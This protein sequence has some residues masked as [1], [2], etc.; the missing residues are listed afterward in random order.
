MALELNIN[1]IFR[2][3]ICNRIGN[4]LS[5]PIL[6]DIQ[7]KGIVEIDETINECK[8]GTHQCSENAACEYLKVRRLNQ[9][10]FLLVYLKMTVNLCRN[11]VDSRP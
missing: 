11:R 7:T 5:E 9:N 6:I 10:K 4:K 1:S 8:L 3:V 2:A